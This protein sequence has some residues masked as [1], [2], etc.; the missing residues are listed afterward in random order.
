MEALRAGFLGRVGVLTQPERRAGRGGKLRGTPVRE[1][2]LELGLE[3][4]PDNLPDAIPVGSIRA[5][6]LVM[7]MAYGVLLKKSFLEWADWG[8][9]NLHASLLPRYRGASPIETAI[10]EGDGVSGVTLMKM[11]PRMDAGPMGP[12][13]EIPLERGETRETLRRKVAGEAGLMVSAQLAG[14]RKGRVDFR[15]QREEEAT[16]CRIL[17]KEDAFLDFESPAV[18]LERRIRAFQPWPGSCFEHAGAILKAGAAMVVDQGRH[19]GGAG[20][21]RAVGREG[22]DIQ[23][24]EG[25][26]RLLQLQRP[27]GRML[28]ADEFLRG[29]RLSEGD[30]FQGKR[31]FPLTSTKPFQHPTRQKTC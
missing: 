13:T 21:V 29:Y 19:R 23:C 26:L 24:G 18:V 11:I 6:E 8:T 16:Y 9:Y 17:T 31:A 3:V 14:I 12:A 15:A 10:A 1:R 22:V 4:L 20:R 5:P 28:P 25:I 7:V 2:A 27:G 30:T